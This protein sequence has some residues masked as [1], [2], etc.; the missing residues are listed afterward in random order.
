MEHKI[1]LLERDNTRLKALLYNAITLLID[2][3]YDNYAT[4]GME[5]EWVDMITRELGCTVSDLKTYA[6][7]TV[8][9]DGKIEV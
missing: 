3:T 8:S 7:I 5:S 9:V 4:E 1:K 2:E 6:G